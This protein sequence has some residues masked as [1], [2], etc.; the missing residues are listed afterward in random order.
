MNRAAEFLA[1]SL[2]IF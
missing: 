2:F 1:Q